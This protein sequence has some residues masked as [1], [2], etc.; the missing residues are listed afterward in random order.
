MSIPLKTICNLAIEALKESEYQES[1]IKEYSKTFSHL[2]FFAQ[3]HHTN[4]YSRKLGEM[5]RSDTISERTGKYSLYR[6]KRRNRCVEMFNWYE[7]HGY[8]SLNAYTRP[9]IETP[10]RV[11][12]QKLHPEY[13]SH[14]SSEGLKPNTIDSFRN[15]SCKFLQFLEKRGYSSLASVT[16]DNVISFMAELR[17]TWAE[18]SLRT[19]V[20]VL[21]S[22]LR[23]AEEPSL[24]KAADCIRTVRARTII[25]ILSDE[26]ENL[27]YW[28]N[29]P[30]SAT[31][32]YSYGSLR[33]TFRYQDILRATVL[34]GRFSNV[35][36]YSIVK[37]SVAQGSCVIMPHRSC[38]KTVCPLKPLLPCWAIRIPTQQRYI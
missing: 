11:L 9:R 27:I 7:A 35:P 2:K 34:S 28:R 16:P 32:P 33:L 26:E 1:T 5:F 20:S 31:V 30:K 10:G 13:L 22:F 14:I 21:R 36:V 15:V 17:K 3:K 25:P 29:A 12:F 38:L 37:E 8:F 6:W 4:I 24:L 19:A 18:E 23:F